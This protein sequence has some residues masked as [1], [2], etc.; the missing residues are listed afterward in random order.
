MLQDILLFFVGIIVG[1]MNSI[2][3]GGMLIGF[4]ILLAIG[5]PPL[6]ANATTPIAVL[7]GQISSAFG[8]RKFL[9]RVSLR[10]LWLII[11][12]A[13]G[14]FGGA[15]LLRNTSADHFAK[16]I[17]LLLIIGVGLFVLQP[18]LHL[19]LYKHI[20]NRK[21]SYWPIVIAGL[22]ILPIAFYGGFFGVGYGFLMLALL[23]FT[24]LKDAHMINALKNVSAVIVCVTAL[25]ALSNSGLVNWH[26]GLL[27]GA[28]TLIGGYLGSRLALNTSSHSLRLTISIVGI[29]SVIYLT[30][31]EY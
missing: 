19:H 16:I 13:L 28:G 11:P 25:L 15:M 29:L 22:A 7:P 26:L 17:P 1:G 23:S 21:K 30:V 24:N 20:K 27:L 18:L 10:Y 3:G 9:S 8:Y 6:I 2:A 12:T 5:F 4:P 31:I 14:S